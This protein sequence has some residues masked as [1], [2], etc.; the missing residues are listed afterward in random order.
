MKNL[1]VNFTR[2]QLFLILAF[3]F[4]FGGIFGFIYETIFYKMDL[5]FFVK[6]GSTFG[7]W[8][9]IYGY[10]S[11]CIIILCNKLKEKPL[12]LFLA[13]AF[14]ASVIEFTTGYY[15][16]HVHNVRLW[17]Y[18]EEMWNF[19]NIGGYV[20]LRSTVFFG[21]SGLFLIYIVLPIVKDMCNKISIKFFTLISLVPALLFTADIIIYGILK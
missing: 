3:V 17:N 19:G 6:R 21:L 11:V 4:T 10:G 16:Y 7:P 8:V 15:L 5:G 13:S 18:Y 2:Y 20:C 14:I 9:P 12:L 1:K